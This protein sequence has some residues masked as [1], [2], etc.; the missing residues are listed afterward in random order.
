M[1]ILHWEIIVM[2]CATNINSDGRNERVADLL[3]NRL[4]PNEQI[5]KVGPFV[6][7]GH[8]YP[9]LLQKQKPEPYRGQHAH[10]NRGIVS[11]SYV[12]SGSLQYDD[13]HHNSG[14]IA[15]GGV[16]WR[17]TGCG[18]IHNERPDPG[19]FHS[20]E[21][22]IN[23]PGINKQEEPECLALSAGDL[24]ELELPG[25]AGLLK[26]LLGTCGA[27]QSPLKTFLKEFIYHIRLNPKSSFSYPAKQE[28]EYAA[29]VPADAI[30]IDDQMIGDSHLLVF[31]R[32]DSPIQLYNPAIFATDVFIF[33]G[34]EY[35]EPIVV[36]GPFVMNTRKE[37]AQAYGDFF[38]GKYKKQNV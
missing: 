11:L 17:N 9:I 24:P 20:I 13:S 36:G 28:Y 30:R 2:N 3:L 6:S 5:T 26:V 32:N 38:A 16:L 14:I 35:L 27:L 31:S 15:C 22:W 33:G 12:L 4:L 1:T 19:L 8:V 7:L 25:N 23:L 37:I 18:V 21:F 10:P 34:L 29:F